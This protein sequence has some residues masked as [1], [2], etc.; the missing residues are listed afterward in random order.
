MKICPRMK[1]RK[2]QMQKFILPDTAI[3]RWSCEHKLILLP[4]SVVSSGPWDTKSKSF[5]RYLN[6]SVSLLFS[7]VIHESPP[8]LHSN[9]VNYLIEVLNTHT[10]TTC[11]GHYFRLEWVSSACSLSGLLFCLQHSIPPVW[12]PLLPSARSTLHWLPQRYRSLSLFVSLVSRETVNS[13]REAQSLHLWVPSHQELNKC[14]QHSRMKS[15]FWDSTGVRPQTEWLSWASLRVTRLVQNR[16]AP[17]GK[18]QC[19]TEDT[20]IKP[21]LKISSSVLYFKSGKE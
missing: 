3:T 7:L 20:Q 14:F 13:L 19:H 2:V 21:L 17:S 12:A 10:S 9:Q 11:I 4:S 6:P 8:T 1:W 5:C 16:S 18:R 15:A